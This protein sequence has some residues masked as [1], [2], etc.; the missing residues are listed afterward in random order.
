MYIILDLDLHVLFH[1]LVTNSVVIVSHSLKSRTCS[2]NPSPTL[3][4]LR[5]K[6]LLSPPVLKSIYY[7][8]DLIYL[9]KYVSLNI[10]CN[11]T[12]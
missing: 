4:I 9:C 3:C 10:I 7:I 5:H 2:L 12:H 11:K 6:G 1:K 8:L